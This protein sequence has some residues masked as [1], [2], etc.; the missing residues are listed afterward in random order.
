MNLSLPFALGPSVVR[1]GQW[2]WPFVHTEKTGKCV[3]DSLLCFLLAILQ[4][5]LLGSVLYLQR[6]RDATGS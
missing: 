5:P 4:L 3:F 6:A 2:E 1:V